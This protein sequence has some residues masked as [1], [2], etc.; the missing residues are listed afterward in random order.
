VG[1]WS[2]SALGQF[3]EFYRSGGWGKMKGARER[4]ERLWRER[5]KTD[6]MLYRE[7]LTLDHRWPCDSR[8][9]A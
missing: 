7:K 2:P 4:A 6:G 8:P 9:T 5:R 3:L 1:A